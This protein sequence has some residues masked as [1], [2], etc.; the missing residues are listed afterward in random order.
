MSDTQNLQ[1]LFSVMHADSGGATM[2]RTIVHTDAVPTNVCNIHT[3][4]T[5]TKQRFSTTTIDR[6]SLGY[7]RTRVDVASSHEESPTLFDRMH[8][9]QCIALQV[10]NPASKGRPDYKCITATCKWCRVRAGAHLSHGC[11][12]SP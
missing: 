7:Y 4:Y 9:G 12:L 10:A 2:Q 5:H 3:R 11:L 8:Q 1:V 6:D